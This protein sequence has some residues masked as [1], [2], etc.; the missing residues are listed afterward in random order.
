LAAEDFAISCGTG[1]LAVGKSSWAEVKQVY[2]R[3]QTLGMSTVYHPLGVDCSFMFTKKT[4]LLIKADFSTP[5]IITARNV[6]VNDP[7]AL[8]TRNYGSSFKK[9]YYSNQPQVFDAIY[10][11]GNYIVF[12]IENDMVKRIIVYCEA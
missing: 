4:N 2:P 8:V 1:T 10:G 12:K 5:A 7:F 9:V 3:G 6:K 11:S